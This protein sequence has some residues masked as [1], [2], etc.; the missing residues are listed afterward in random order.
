MVINDIRYMWSAIDSPWAM[1][2]RR[3]PS[4]FVVLRCESRWKNGIGLVLCGV[5][6]LCGGIVERTVCGVQWWVVDGV[7]WE[8]MSEL[9]P[10]MLV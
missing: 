3:Q 5:G 8:R 10:G 6:R 1:P 4:R 7:L 2:K 9:G